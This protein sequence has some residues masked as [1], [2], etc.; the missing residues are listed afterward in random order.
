MPQYTLW[1]EKTWSQTRQDLALTFERWGVHHWSVDGRPSARTRQ[2]MEE[3]QVTILFVH[4]TG[5][6]I[7]VT[8]SDLARSVDNFRA[9]YL[10]LEDMRM[11]EK[12]GV[13][14]VVREAYLQLAAPAQHR[15]PYEILGV[16]PDSPAEVIDAAYRA[17]SKRLHPDVGGS[18]EAMAELNAAYER[19]KGE[20]R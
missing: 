2:S 10:A 17:Q 11:M 12:R 9:L 19:V 18:F 15:D 6:D 8:K 1:T 3:R 16:R 13:A 7:T 20:A 14:D 5:R 4:P